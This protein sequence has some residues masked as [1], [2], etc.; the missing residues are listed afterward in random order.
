MLLSKEKYPFGHELSMI[1]ILYNSEKLERKHGAINMWNQLVDD[2][3]SLREYDMDKLF[4]PR[5]AI[6]MSLISDGDDVS[7][8][9][10]E[11]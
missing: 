8:E 9:D 3:S 6:Y 4:G 1:A 11:L 2:N 7:I 5:S 10:G